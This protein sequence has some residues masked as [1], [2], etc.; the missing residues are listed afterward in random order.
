MAVHIKRWHIDAPVDPIIT[1]SDIP[2]SNNHLTCFPNAKS[3]IDGDYIPFPASMS[4]SGLPFAIFTCLVFVC[5][6]HILPCRA[7]DGQ[8]I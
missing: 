3:H 2:R 7:G 1:Q 6:R 8:A 4:N 5:M